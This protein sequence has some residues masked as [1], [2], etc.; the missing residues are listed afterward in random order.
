MGQGKEK[1]GAPQGDRRCIDCAGHYALCQQFH[2][3]KERRADGDYGG[4][5]GGRG[6]TDFK[7]R[8]DGAK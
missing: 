8:R 7:H 2:D 3:G 6:G 1:E 5:I 4:G